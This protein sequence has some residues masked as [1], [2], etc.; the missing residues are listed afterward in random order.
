MPTLPSSNGV[1]QEQS[2]AVAA[3]RAQVVRRGRVAAERTLPAWWLDRLIVLCAL[4]TLCV[5]S[6]GLVLAMLGWFS[7]WIVLVLS[8]PVVAAVAWALRHVFKAVPLERA[9]TIG[10]VMAVLLA[11]VSLAWFTYAPSHH[12]LLDRDPGAYVATAKWIGSTGGLE[13]SEADGPFAGRSDVTFGSPAVYDIGDGRLQFQFNHFVGAFLAV[14]DGMLGEAVLFRVL[15]A[16]AAVGLLAL[17]SVTVRATGRPIVSLVAPALVAVSLP[18]LSVARDTYSEVPT[19]LVLWSGLLVLDETYRRPRVLAGCLGGLLMGAT[20]LVRVDGVAYLVVVA[21]FVVALW[22]AHVDEGHRSRRA[23]SACLAAC[24][25]VAAVGVYG[26][27]VFSRGYFDA[28]RSQI[29]GLWALVAVVAV[30]GMAAGLLIARSA[31][32]RS[33]IERARRPVASAAG[34]L[35]VTVLVLAWVIRPRWS[36]GMRSQPMWSLMGELQQREGDVVE[37]RRTYA[38]DTMVRM[39]WYLGVP[40]LALGILGVGRSVYR[41]LV[42]GASAAL[43]LVTS[44]F[45]TGGAMYLWNPRINPDQI[46]SAR[47]FVPAVLPCLAVAVVVSLSW[48]LEHLSGRRGKVLV[49]GVAAV[50]VAAAAW[51]AMPVPLQ[52]EQHGYAAVIDEL[53]DRLPPDAAVLVVGHPWSNVLPQTLRGWCGVP[54]GVAAGELASSPE[55]LSGLAAAVAEEGDQLWVVSGDRTSLAAAEAAAGSPADS[56]AAV[57]AT[58]RLE[59]TLNR[60]PS[61]YMADDEYLYLPATLQLHAVRVLGVP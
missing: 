15:G 38:E 31:D 13:M 24:A 35:V 18:F 47:R 55:A 42:G 49:A 51:T 16:V 19:L 40:A 28:L 58:N 2:I 34:W 1:M 21:G 60:I 56:T 44:L 3:E 54:V 6:V 41:S 10:G 9:T 46:W 33:S 45:L 61:R 11:A 50:A 43:V 17:Y 48:A 27:L 12:V 26:T 36:V 57:T 52:R 53:C 30:G 59:H 25:V 7:A 8:A 39:G 37:L 22:C 5:G 4:G 29:L 14:F 32:L 20:V 23:A